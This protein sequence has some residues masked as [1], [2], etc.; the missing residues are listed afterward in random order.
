MLWIEEMNY[1]IHAVCPHAWW[2]HAINSRNEIMKCSFMCIGD[3]YLYLLSLALLL[4]FCCCWFTR[5]IYFLD[6]QAAISV[7]SM[8]LPKG[9]FTIHVLWVHTYICARFCV[10]ECL[11]CMRGILVGVCL[12]V[13]TLRA[14]LQA[15]CKYIQTDMHVRWRPIDCLCVCVLV[16]L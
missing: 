14:Y 1:T 9:T 2:S 15:W 7:C 13:L 5:L 4:C 12:C 8:Q 11:T 16:L 3:I 6:V 10:C